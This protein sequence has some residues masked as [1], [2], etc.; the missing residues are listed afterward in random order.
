MNLC[1]YVHYKYLFKNVQCILIYSKTYVDIAGANSWLIGNIMML[2]II[3]FI[4]FNFHQLIYR[5]HYSKG[6]IMNIK[7]WRTWSF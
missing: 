3:K 2:P 5:R 6:Y 4:D 1:K 7:V